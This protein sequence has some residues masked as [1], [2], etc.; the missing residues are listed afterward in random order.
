[1]SAVLS[2]APNLSFFCGQPYIVT[3]QIIALVLRFHLVYWTRDLVV[4]E[5]ESISLAHFG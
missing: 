4:V 3:N 5:S 1:M 2:A